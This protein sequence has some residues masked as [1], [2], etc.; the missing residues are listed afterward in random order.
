MIPIAQI[1]ENPATTQLAGREGYMTMWMGDDRRLIM[2]PCSNNTIMNFV[3]IHPSELSASKG[4]GMSTMESDCPPQLTV[5]GWNR[6]VS[7]EVLLD[8]YSSFEATV[9]ALL[10]MVDIEA[11]KVWTLLDMD[12]IPRWYTGKLALLGDAAHPFLPHQ[13]QGG[14]T[15]HGSQPNSHA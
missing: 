2:Y 10:E 7:K 15:F 5:P 9:K 6:G 11:L 1:R 4:E 14:K 3:G 13:G 12:K 8:V